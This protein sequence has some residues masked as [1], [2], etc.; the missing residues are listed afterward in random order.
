MRYL[1]LLA[2]F[3]C[4]DSPSAKAFS[5]ANLTFELPPHWTP[6]GA[7]GKAMAT[8]APDKNERGESIVFV[9]ADP[10]VSAVNN[11]AV[12]GELFAAAQGTLT[13]EKVDVTDART[14]DGMVGSRVDV[15]YTPPGMHVRYHRVHFLFVDGKQLVHVIYTAR[16]RDPN[17]T[18]VSTLLRSLH[19]V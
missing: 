5:F 1:V 15:D 18:A 8:W 14:A 19:Q 12:I 4:N 2:L 11:H 3:A 7:A 17:L 13:T 10:P 9:R 16:D 6:S